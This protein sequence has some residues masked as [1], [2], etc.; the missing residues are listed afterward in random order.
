MLDESA[1]TVAE[2]RFREG[3]WRTAPGEAVE[4]AEV[5]SRRFGPILASVFGDLPDCSAINLIQGAAEP[6]AVEG[7][8]LIAAIVRLPDQG[9]GGVEPPRCRA[10][11]DARP[12]TCD[13]RLHRREGVAR[14]RRGGL[15]ADRRARAARGAL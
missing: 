12:R 8:H 13:G 9:L 1:I 3:L 10:T 2:F 11:Q 7:G 15:E 5:R 6:G 14:D 4:E